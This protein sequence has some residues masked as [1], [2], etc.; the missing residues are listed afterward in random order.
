[1][2]RTILSKRNDQK[3]KRIGVKDYLR[4]TK[5]PKGCKCLV[6]FRQ[7][8]FRTSCISEGKDKINQKIK[9]MLYIS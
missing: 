1:M 9:G 2:A 6:F 5:R 3:I 4:L 8:D 7:D